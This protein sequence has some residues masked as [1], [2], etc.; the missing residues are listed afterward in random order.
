MPVG[1]DPGAL[2]ATSYTLERGPRV[3]LRLVRPRDLDGVRRLLE[4]RGI[5]PDELGLARLVRAHPRRTLVICA[6]ALVGA[7]EMVVGIGAIDLAST[8]AQPTW[9]VV[10][11]ELTEGLEQLLCD[12]LLGRARALASSRAA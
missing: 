5:E 11:E 10:D 7:R 3:C 4:R 2:L 9:V 8:P 6:T 12:A 1:F